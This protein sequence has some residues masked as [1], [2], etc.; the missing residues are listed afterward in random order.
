VLLLWPRASGV[1]VSLIGILVC[2]PFWWG[3]DL[4]FAW[5]SMVEIIAFIL[6]G[7]TFRRS[8]RPESSREGRSMTALI[9]AELLKLSTRAHA[10]VL[11]VAMLFVP[12][13]VSSEIPEPGRGGTALPIDDP[14]LL[15][16][17]VGTGFVVPMV[18]VALLGGVAVTQEYRYGTVTSTYLIEPRRHRVLTAKIGALAVASLL[19][20]AVTLKVA[21]PVAVALISTRGGHLHVG[22]RFWQTVTGCA[23]VMLLYAVVGAL[24]GAL[25][26]NQVAFVVAALVWM[27]AVEHLLIPAHMSLGRWLPVAAAYQLMQLGPSVDPDGRLL[28]LPASGLLLAAYAT[29]VVLLAFALTPKRDIH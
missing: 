6:I 22:A 25:V 3:F 5:L 26:R 27:L 29:I 20:T 10:G 8:G 18:F 21:G 19:T 7:W 1:L 12:I 16:L 11:L 28:P 9:D 15:A 13:A 4:P 23:V 17:A 24:I 2:A 14:D